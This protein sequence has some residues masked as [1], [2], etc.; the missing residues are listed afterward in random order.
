MKII[1]LMH[2]QSVLM[3]LNVSSKNE[4]INV[5][6]NALADSGTVTDKAS[7]QEAVIN[8]EKVSS[9]G[10]GFNVAIPHGKSAGVAK[11]GLAFAQLTSPLDW[12]SIDGKPVS[13]VFMIAV[14]E[15][16]SGN[17]HLHILMALSRKLMDD[18]FRNQ[19]LSARDRGELMELL[20]T[21]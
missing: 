11:P 9:T 20:G 6:V 14:P 7:Y 21:I 13:I 8:R 5:L 15:K 12:D 2:E 16:S 19:L 18:D 4:C 17:E 1:D 3:P 10:I